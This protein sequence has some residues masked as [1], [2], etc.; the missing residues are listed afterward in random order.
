MNTPIKC[1]VEGTDLVMRI[2]IGT[3]AFAAK[4]KNGGP[5]ENHVRI[6]DKTELAKDVANELMRENEIG[7]FP[8]ADYLDKAIEAAA[9]SGSVAFVYPR[10]GG[11]RRS[12]SGDARSKAEKETNTRI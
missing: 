8:M 4:K 11:R 7:N 6:V 5:I 10:Q 12:G 9:E 3:L 1:S 2:G